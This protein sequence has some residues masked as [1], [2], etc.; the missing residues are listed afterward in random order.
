MK[1]EYL[2]LNADSREEQLRHAELL[3]K[4]EAQKRARGI[5]VPTSIPEIK[6]RLRELNQPTT[7]FG[8]DHA[9][10][11]E[12]LRAVIARLELGEEELAQLQVFECKILNT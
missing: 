2:D 4:H 1:A 9:D 12:R 5:I 6:Y 11:R 8:E 3:K 7:L 10:R